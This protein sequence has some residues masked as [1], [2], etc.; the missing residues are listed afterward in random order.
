MTTKQ[1][2]VPRR[3]FLK[4]ILAAGT[5][6]YF[7]PSSALGADGRP[8]PSNRIVMGFVGVGGQGSGDMGGFMG[9][10]EVQVVAVCDVDARHRT[11]A[12]NNVEGRYARQKA[13]GTY[14]GCAD[15]ND[16]REL[17]TRPDID[18]VFCATPDHWHALVTV[19]ALRNGKDVYCEKPETLTIREGRI[20]IETARRY[21]R[22]FSGGSQRVWE[23]YNWYHRMVRGGA[24]GD[25][26]E[27]WVNVGGASDEMLRPAQTVP[28]GM[29]WDRWLGPAPWRPYNKDYHPFNWRGCRD[30]SGGNMTDWGAHHYGGTLFCIN[31]QNCPGPVE[32][33]PPDG[34]EYKFLT[35]KFANGLVM[36]DGGAWGGPMSFRGTKGELPDRKGPRKAPPDINIPNYK[37]RGGI[38]GDFLHCVRTRQRP[39]RD[40]ELA[41]HTLVVCHLGNIAGWLK[42][43][44]K[45]DPDKEQIIG[46]PEANRWLDRPKRAPWT[47]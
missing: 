9:F 35:W 47:L 34:K 21:G 33:I 8:A 6:P 40:I 37:G 45:F 46:D 43:P 19:E 5:A 22:V 32:V 12:K 16:Y 13:D 39:F 14:K 1:R 7:I 28:D 24:I 2:Q 20:M 15:Y 31:M 42:R 18:A 36:H 4:G 3:L 11:S 23:D 30:F 41:H 44:I 25:V 10:P 26:L 27:A 29:D 17:V 38:F